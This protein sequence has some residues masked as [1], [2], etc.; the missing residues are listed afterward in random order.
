MDRFKHDI[1]RLSATRLD[2]FEALGKQLQTK[3]GDVRREGLRDER[4]AERGALGALE[5]RNI[6]LRSATDEPGHANLTFDVALP[7]IVLDG[8]LWDGFTMYPARPDA[9]D[10]RPYWSANVSGAKVVLGLASDH[11]TVT[12]VSVSRR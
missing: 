11:K 12:Y 4:T 6:S 9:P 5:I 1:E 8:P 2:D 3:L 7:S 10:S